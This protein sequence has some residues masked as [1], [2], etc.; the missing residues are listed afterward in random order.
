[1]DL[2][3]IEGMTITNWMDDGFYKGCV[4]FK[5]GKSANKNVLNIFSHIVAWEKSPKG[6]IGIF[7]QKGDFWALYREW[8]YAWNE[9]TPLEV[10]SKYE[11]VEIENELWKR[12]E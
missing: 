11:I 8:N 1:M 9:E 5:H 6:T 7:P 10:K 3:F 4:H 2:I 12:L